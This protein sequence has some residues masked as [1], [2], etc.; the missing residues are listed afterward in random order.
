VVLQDH[1]PATLHDEEGL[2]AGSGPHHGA[3]VVPPSC[4]RIEDADLV[5]RVELTCFFFL[6]GAVD[7]AEEPVE[8]PEEDAA[9]D[10][11]AG[12]GAAGGTVG[13]SGSRSS[14]PWKATAGAGR[15]SAMGA[16]RKAKSPASNSSLVRHF[17]IFFLCGCAV[18]TRR[19]RLG[20]YSG[21]KT[22]L[23]RTGLRAWRLHLLFPL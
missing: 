5:E 20:T 2:V 12:D 22:R 17:S 18:C 9:D 16:L 21:D 19:T 6:A 7:D 10:S 14:R 4:V 23:S 11:A 8:E 13:R 15:P 3:G 1:S